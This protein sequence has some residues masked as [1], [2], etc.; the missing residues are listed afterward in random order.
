MI[1]IYVAIAV[2]VLIIGFGCW[3]LGKMD[4]M[5]DA[6]DHYARGFSVGQ[7]LV[8]REAVQ[9]GFGY[10]GPHMKIVEHVL[11]PDYDTFRWHTDRYLYWKTDE[12]V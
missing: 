5:R 7:K 2:C 1:W 10:D 8:Q 11:G 12:G 3:C 4:G 9:Y 6:G